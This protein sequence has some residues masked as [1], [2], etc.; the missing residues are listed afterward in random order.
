MGIQEGTFEQATSVPPP[1]AEVKE[2]SLETAEGIQEFLA[3]AEEAYTEAQQFEGWAKQRDYEGLSSDEVDGDQIFTEMYIRMVDIRDL[4]ALP[5]ED[6]SSADVKEMQDCYDDILK[7]RD[8]VFNVYE[9]AETVVAQ[10]FEDDEVEVSSEEVIPP[11]PMLAEVSVE[12]EPTEPT[13]EPVEI[14]NE[15]IAAEEPDKVFGAESETTLA[16]EQAEI[17]RVFLRGI[18]MRDEFTRSG[19]L[20]ESGPL[21]DQLKSSLERARVIQD[22]TEEMIAGAEDPNVVSIAAEKYA[23]VTEEIDKNLTAIEDV[24]NSKVLPENESEVEPVTALEE[25]ESEQKTVAEEVEEED[26]EPELEPAE[27]TEPALET[28]PVLPSESGPSFELMPTEADAVALMAEVKQ[29]QFYT[30]EERQTA[31]SMLEM[32]H[33]SVAEGKDASSVRAQFKSLNDYIANLD[34][35]PGLEYIP[36]RIDRILKRIEPASDGTDFKETIHTLK[37]NYDR[38]QTEDPDNE[39]RIVSAYKNIAEMATSHE[40]EWLSVCGMRMPKAGPEGVFSARSMR[41]G[42]LLSRDRH[43]ELVQN[44]NKQVLVDK[45]VRLLADVPSEG[46]NENELEELKGLAR[47]IDISAKVVG[48]LHRAESPA[49]QPTDT[50]SRSR[51]GE[52]T[53]I[54]ADEEDHSMAW[55]ENEGVTEAS[56]TKLEVTKEE[57]DDGPLVLHNNTEGVHRVSSEELAAEAEVVVEAEDVSGEENPFAAAQEAERRRA[58]EEAED[59]VVSEETTSEE[60]AAEAEEAIAAEN[61]GETVVDE[62]VGEDLPDADEAVL[63]EVE[64][65]DPVNEAVP[66]PEPADRPTVRS[67]QERRAEAGSLVELSGLMDEYYDFFEEHDP[68]EF[69]KVVRSEVAAYERKLSD[70]L[71][72]FLGIKRRSAFEL[73]KGMTLGEISDLIGEYSAA[74]R[75]RFEERFNV[76]YD[77]FLSW[78]DQ[79]DEMQK[80]VETNDEMS[81]GELY[82]RWILEQELR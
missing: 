6:L 77:T 76:R 23:R 18:E 69:D 62:P 56:S 82:A 19:K 67:W 35:H 43:T 31:Q 66:E 21:F 64:A 24:L 44:P 25:V 70:G 27:S 41:E 17:K 36:E 80:L 7:L 11:E 46:L 2:I 51:A 71:E 38:I 3:N 79:I 33:R 12:V 29:N 50:F 68:T 40:E 65:E 78:S 42:L 47:E 14:P 55:P 72:N 28:E 59:A 9:Q 22:K 4:A 13:A 5:P 61:D 73:M 8:H 81:F 15:P 1:E 52:E 75:S 54:F 58:A 37:E 60:I 10:E 48:N 39:E 49:E 32:F 20:Q 53:V 26:G 45:M 57:A 34:E 30:A 16:N 63:A 74:E